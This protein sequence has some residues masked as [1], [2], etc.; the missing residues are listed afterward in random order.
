MRSSARTIIK[1]P[2]SVLDLKRPPTSPGEML[3][4]E[5]L[6]PGAAP[7]W[8]RTRTPARDYLPGR[9]GCFPD[10]PY[11]PNVLPSLTRSGAIC[12]ST[13]LDAACPVSP[14]SSKRTTPPTAAPRPAHSSL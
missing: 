9:T 8:G 12:M 14:G 3:R 5:F 2:L 1:G 10:A 13:A 4:E 11:Q 6:R 7:H